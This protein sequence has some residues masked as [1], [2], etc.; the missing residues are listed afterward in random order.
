MRVSELFVKC[1]EN[2]GVE[3]IFG[4]PGEENIDF[5]EALKESEIEFITTRH[6][7]GAA[8][9]A[10]VYGKLTGKPGVCLGTLG[11]GA[12]NLL[13]GVAEAN[14]DKTPLIA[15]T[16][17]A[18]LEQQHK[19]S[20]QFYD[21]ISMFKPVTKW[22]T[23]IRDKD[24]VPEVVRKAFQ[25][26]V[27][28]KPGAAHIELP[29]DIAELEVEGTLQEPWANKML[30]RALDKAID[31]A[32]QAIDEAEN[33]IILVG[34]G[35]T[36]MRASEPLR[37]FVEKIRAPFTSTFMG[38][39]AITYEHPQNLQTV[40]LQEKDHIVCGIDKADLIITVGF[41]FAEYSPSAWNPDGKRQIIHIDT[42]PAEV[43][44]CYP[45]EVSVVGD[46]VENLSQLTEKVNA[47]EKMAPFFEKLR[48]EIMEDLAEHEEDI[49]YP[50]KPQKIAA[51]LRAV[52]DDDA[53]LLSDVGAHK[54]WLARYFHCI[55]PNTCLISNGF[56]SMGIA[57]P[58][59][60]GAK[61]AFPDKKV[62]AV[63]GDGG[64]LMTV[65]ELE[66]M[67][68]L[69]LSI[70]VVVWTDNRYGLIEWKQMNEYDRSSSI[71]FENP[72]IVQLAKAFGAEGMKVL[73][74]EEFK[75]LLER[76]FELEKPVIIDCP[77]DFKENVRLTERLGNIICSN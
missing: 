72:D 21:L 50:M 43:D 28:E 49:S 20:H 38:K 29:E 56:A 39:G 66:T 34:N 7:T 63:A 42:Q 76:A 45:I 46:I 5:L 24:I 75:P 57:L 14:M 69:K 64:F 37:R 8:F 47:R 31:D 10:G 62:V 54:M 23:S 32:A 55:K 65:Q 61:L 51:D 12:T 13:T 71:T 41:D 52:L 2:E 68:R 58:G 59:A 3:Y 70:V 33:P 16:G 53:I 1:L 73:R 77:V 22:N 30:T 19:K 15:I 25:Q 6:E 44:M 48:N 27:S 67:V 40:G 4:V 60:I 35:V 18:G 26:A 17:Q 74:A 11:P 36:R 9:M